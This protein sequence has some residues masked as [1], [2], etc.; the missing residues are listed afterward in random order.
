MK[1]DLVLDSYNERRRLIL[2]INRRIILAWQLFAYASA[3]C[4]EDR[5]DLLWR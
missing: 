4:L 5:D 1:P 3:A 2:P